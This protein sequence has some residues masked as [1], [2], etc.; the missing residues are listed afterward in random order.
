MNSVSSVCQS[1]CLSVY[2]SVFT[3]FLRIGSLFFSDFLN[4]VRGPLQLKSDRARFFRK[5]LI[6][7]KMVKKGP[8][9]AK[10]WFLVFCGKWGH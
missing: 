4:E 9:R 3:I 6:F 2:L 1:V 8:K 7:P 10:I 5:I